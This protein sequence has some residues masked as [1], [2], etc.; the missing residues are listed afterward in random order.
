MISSNKSQNDDIL[1]KSSNVLE[2]I[3]DER[4]SKINGLESLSIIVPNDLMGSLGKDLTPCPA[5]PIKKIRI[6]VINN[7][8]L[9]RHYYK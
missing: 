5:L 2:S 3:S 8:A 1:K 6:G 4:P 9:W 7:Y